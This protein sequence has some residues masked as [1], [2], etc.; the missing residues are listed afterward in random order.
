[1]INVLY[2]VIV[3]PIDHLLTVHILQSSLF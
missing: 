1:M 2:N 3:R